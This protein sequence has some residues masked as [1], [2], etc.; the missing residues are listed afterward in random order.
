MAPKS[1]AMPFVL[2]TLRLISTPGGYYHARHNQTLPV[3]PHLHRRP[4]LRQPMPAPRGV[5]LL[6]PHHPPPGREPRRPPPPPGSL[7][8][9]LP[10]DRSAIQR[11]IGEVLL[12]IARN[13][14]DPKRAGLLLYGLQIASLNLPPVPKKSTRDTYPV[15]E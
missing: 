11:S 1:G 14:I 13:E 10:E 8:H 3:P 15:E 12:R 7:R 2:K 6:P 5:L 4:P 9:P